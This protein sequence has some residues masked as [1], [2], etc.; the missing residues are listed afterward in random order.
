[1]KKQELQR[2]LA[3]VGRLTRG[4]RQELVYRLKAQSN[5]E[6]SV[7]VL[8]STG[9]QARTRPH[10]TSQRLVRNGITDGPPSRRPCTSQA[11]W[12]RGRGRRPQLTSKAP[13]LMSADGCD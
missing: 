4:Q 1:M 7:E 10:C 12:A 8:E 2:L 6:A 11:R 3:L 13:F 9:S 5:A